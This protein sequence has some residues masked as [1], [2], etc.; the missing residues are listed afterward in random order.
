MRSE[1]QAFVDRYE[2]KLLSANPFVPQ[3]SLLHPISEQQAAAE[4]MS[5]IRESNIVKLPSNIAINA[6]KQSLV[7]LDGWQTVVELDASTWQEHTFPLPIGQSSGVTRIRVLNHSGKSGFAVFSELGKSVFFFDASWQLIGEFQP[8]QRSI[9]DVQGVPGTNGQTN[10]LL[11]V[12]DGSD[13]HSIDVATMTERRG[14]AVDGAKSVICLSTER[15]LGGIIAQS[16]VVR[17][18]GSCVPL[19]REL[20]PGR[21]LDLGN[22][23]I[24]QLYSCNSASR[25]ALAITLNQSG[26]WEAVGLDNRFEVVWVQAIGPQEFNSQIEPATVLETGSDVVWAVAGADDSVAVIAGN[27]RLFYRLIAPSLIRGLQWFRRPQASLR[28]R[29]CCR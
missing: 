2:E 12:D 18:D 3:Q 14:Q 23:R 19:D 26:Q 24:T 27:G 11:I 10:E 4:P 20:H 6:E 16:I 8:K 5:L 17:G 7:V 22:R 29:W 28:Q 1:Y 15:P 21:I 25:S 13:V 9:C